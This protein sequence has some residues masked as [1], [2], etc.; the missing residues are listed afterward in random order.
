LYKGY[1]LITEYFRFGLNLAFELSFKF[2]ETEQIRTCEMQPIPFNKPYVSGLELDNIQQAH[3]AGHLSGNGPFSTACE[4][5]LKRATGSAA[6]LVTHSCT[7]ALE[8]TALLLE[9]Q[10]GDEVIMPSYTFVSTA[11]AFA[12]R[13]AIPVF[14]DIRPDTLNLD[15][16]LIEEAITERTRAICVVH[17]AGVGAEMDAI[18]ALACRH[19]LT[20]IEDAAQ[21]IAASYKG[22]ALGSLSRFGAFSF[23]ET[24]NATCGEG[25][26]LLL[27]ETRDVEL[28]EI[29]REKG[30]DRSKF[31]RGIV[32]KYTWQ[33][34]GSS[35]LLGEMA[36]A[37]L[38]AQLD[39]VDK[40]TRRRLETWNAYD[41][42]LRP[43]A[44][45]G[46]MTCPTVPPHCR[47]NAHMYYILARSGSHRDQLLEFLRS[48]G[49]G[50]VFHYVPL[51]STPTGRE[52]GRAHGALKNTDDLSARLI[53]LPMWVGLTGDEVNWV[54][55]IIIES[56]N[57]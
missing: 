15:E 16:T 23:H 35:F 25:G 9:L 1:S 47:H 41:G 54:C 56:L 45:A 2:G 48:R 39:I 12:L 29:L 7:A 6:A 17:Y 51:H 50:A 40:L 24:K 14:V 32:D 26:A 46:Q 10:P 18:N 20:V 52:V 4:E 8:M 49:V 33:A 13:G 38:K 19:G 55:D 37:F 27:N 44:D 53:R 34:V 42:R 22:R 5:W 31:M 57:R 3:A 21:G 30:T 11:N 43:L 28:A 36:A